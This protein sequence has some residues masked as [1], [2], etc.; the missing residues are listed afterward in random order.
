MRVVSGGGGKITT[1][2]GVF[3]LIAYWEQAVNRIPAIKLRPI[4]ALKIVLLIYLSWIQRRKEDQLLVV[5]GK[6]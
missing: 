6:A 2:S 4:K 5:A 1:L 3:E